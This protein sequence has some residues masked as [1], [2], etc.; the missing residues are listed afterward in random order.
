MELT[1]GRLHRFFCGEPIRYEEGTPIDA[2]R[3]G[4]EATCSVRVAA[5]GL[6]CKYHN[7][8]GVK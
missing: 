2:T 3:P 7:T 8:K 1:S 5:K 6:K 4:Y